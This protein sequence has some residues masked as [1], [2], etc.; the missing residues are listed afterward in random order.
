[1]WNHNM[2]FSG[3]QTMENT[4]AKAGGRILPRE[5]IHGLA[6]SG[7]VRHL[8]RTVGEQQIPRVGVD[9]R[10]PA[11]IWTRTRND[12]FGIK[13]DSVSAAAPSGGPY[14]RKV[15]IARFDQPTIFREGMG[16]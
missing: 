3:Y 15:P 2:R 13:S 11:P 6:E 10:V 12:H 9:R 1:M 5:S 4:V 8:H 16:N 14:L 7:G